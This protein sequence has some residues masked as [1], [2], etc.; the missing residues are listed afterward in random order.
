MALEILNL[1]CVR[2]ERQIFSGVSLSVS[3]GECVWVRGKNGA[4]KSSL[5]RIVADLLK[6]SSGKITWHGKDIHEDP[7]EFHH[8]FQYIGHQEALKSVL[9]VRE[10]LDFWCDYVG[11]DRTETAL[12]AFQLSDLADFQVRILSAGQKKRS[13][14][15]RLLACPAPLWILDEPVSSLDTHHIELFKSILVD[16]LKN[17]GMALLATHQDLQLAQ[18][19]EFNLDHL[20]RENEFESVL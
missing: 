3:E 15:A 5:L 10:N 6:S 12:S 13:N 4:G 16:H 9:T 17:G 14:L 20:K 18:I 7:D 19:R 8:Q 2:Q 1:G 11:S